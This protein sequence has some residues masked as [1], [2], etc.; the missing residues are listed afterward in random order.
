MHTSTLLHSSY[1]V[2]CTLILLSQSL[3][4]ALP[5]D[6][7]VH[8]RTATTP[9]VDSIF[10]PPHK[11]DLLNTNPQTPLTWV[12]GSSAYEIHLDVTNC[13]D[14]NR[15]TIVGDY[16][17]ISGVFKQDA[18]VNDIKSDEFDLRRQNPVSSAFQKA[19]LEHLLLNAQAAQTELEALFA[20]S[21][22]EGG[23]DELR[24]LLSLGGDIQAAVTQKIKWVVYLTPQIV[25]GWI[26]GYIIA[27]GF[28]HHSNIT[29]LTPTEF[30]VYTAF[31]VGGAAVITAIITRLQN[32]IAAMNDARIPGFLNEAEYHMLAV[33]C[34]W[35]RRLMRQI[36]VVVEREGITLLRG[37]GG[38]WIIDGTV[39]GDDEVV[40]GGA[41]GGGGGAG[42]VV[43]QQ[44][45]EMS[46]LQAPP[47]NPLAPGINA[48]AI[49]PALEQIVVAQEAAAA[50]A[51]QV[52]GSSGG[53]C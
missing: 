5:Q 53:E 29:G 20:P 3:V 38:G 15:D 48:I 46:V 39:R 21:P 28:E 43:V 18:S 7:N 9:K 47:V 35:F 32:Y 14:V 10:T 2:L 31:A 13:W 40:G 26:M 51:A 16:T 23:H 36:R 52:P 49:Q 33:F 50:D 17:L 12:I 41:S 25:G 44:E 22:E 6:P 30:K 11:R 27:E 42:A 45:I 37:M 8:A 1:K 24:K 34:A 19:R 4:S